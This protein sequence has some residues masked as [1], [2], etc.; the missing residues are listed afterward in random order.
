MSF[1]SLSVEILCM[2][3]DE[4]DSVNELLKCRLISKRCNEAVACMRI[5]SLAI[6][7]KFYDRRK[8]AGR[9]YAFTNQPVSST[10]R[11]LT[12]SEKVHHHIEFLGSEIMRA[13]LCTIKQLS[14][15]RVILKTKADKTTFQT[16]INQF[17]QLDHLQVNC[18]ETVQKKYLFLSNVRIFSVLRFAGNHLYLD[19]PKLRKLFWFD[20]AQQTELSERL[21]LEYPEKLTHLTLPFAKQDDLL[22]Y[23]NLKCLELRDIIGRREKLLSPDSF[24]K[25]RELFLEVSS[26]P[27]AIKWMKSWRLGRNPDLRLYMYSVRVENREDI[28]QLCGIPGCL[29]KDKTAFII[30]NYHKIPKHRIYRSKGH[31]DYEKLI[32]HFGD[33]LPADLCSIFVRINKISVR[34]SVNQINFLEFISKCKILKNLVVDDCTFD[35]SFYSNLIDY[36]PFLK[37]IEIDGVGH[38]LPES[39]SEAR[40]FL[41]ELSM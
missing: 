8:F 11:L 27:I 10:S 7:S 23:K 32:Q 35:R 29:T 12:K 4:L 20:Q 26:K 28:D 16:L 40:T 2:I 24:G 6:E 17:A 14:I 18:L 34:G 37:E 19:A 33:P 25:L 39:P 31:I 36:A 3:F 9:F 15:N 5:E 22:K 38:T 13:M 1:N 30:S 41:A 21:H